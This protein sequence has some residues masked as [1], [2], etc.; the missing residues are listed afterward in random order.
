LRTTL[1]EWCRFALADQGLTPARH[2]LL[3]IDAL[4]G[5]A[6]GRTTRLMVLMPPGSAKSTYTSLL[7]PPWWLSR[8]KR[9]AI[10]CASHTVSLAESFGR[11]IR[12][13]IGDHGARLNVSLRDDDR[14][15]GRFGTATGGQYYA[16]GAHGAVAGRR[17]DL[18]IIDDPVASFAACANARGR[19]SIWEWYRADLVTRLRPGGAIILVMTRWH[20]DDLAGRLMNTKGW[21]VLRLPALGE[22]DDPMGRAAGEVLWPEYEDT[23]T[24][25]AKRMELGEYVFSSLYQQTPR[26]PGATLFDISKLTLC[27]WVTAGVSVR[28]WDLAATRAEGGNPDWTV[29]LKLTRLENGRFC[30][31]DIKRLRG[32][33]HEVADLICRTARE[34]GD[35]VTVGLPRDPGQ[36]AIYQ[37]SALTALLAGYRVTVSPEQGAKE[38]RA[39]PVAAQVCA[40]N[41]CLKAAPWNDAFVDELA[42]FPHGRKDDQVDALSR[43]F[44]MLTH[45]P[46]QTRYTHTPLFER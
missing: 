19:D 6:D 27:D 17:A 15:A 33:P 7:F 28:A 46:Q 22:A 43:G 8:H 37:V 20:A 36:A 44:T 38:I 13:L 26:P 42:C 18:I 39:M 35:T 16:I 25:Q 32:G 5:V 11:G 24:L 45:T 40:G 3:L 4:Q 29:G 12:R 14:A 10:I 34:D 23:A 9:G 30:V 31:A 1:A 41:V 2:H 21:T